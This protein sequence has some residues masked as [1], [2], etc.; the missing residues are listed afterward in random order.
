MFEYTSIEQ[1][2]A[3]L[4]E[5]KA[6]CI[7]AIEH[8]LQKIEST[9]HLNAY[10]DVYAEEALSRARQLDEQ[11]ASGKAIGRLHGVVI[12]IKDVIAY[13]DHRLTASSKILSN[14]HSVYSATAI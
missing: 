7:Q 13:K 2:H 11:R 12:G 9:R 8:Y 6:T 14:F 5:G 10:I 3:D 1:Y 4:Q